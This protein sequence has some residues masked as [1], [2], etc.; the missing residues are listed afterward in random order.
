M[1]RLST[2]LLLLFLALFL[3]PPRSEA[4][5]QASSFADIDRYVSSQLSSARIPGAALGIVHGNQ[6]AHLRGFGRADSSSRRVSPTTPFVIGSVS[7]SFTALAVM[8]LVEAGKITLDRPVQRYIPW[9][10]T[11]NRAASRVMSVRD[12]LVQTSGIPTSVGVTPLAERTTTLR[13]Q[14]EALSGVDTG[15]AGS[16][17]EYSNANYEILGQLV[18]TVSGEPYG[19]YVQEHI[20]RPL[21]MRH[22]YMDEG[23]ARRAGLAAGHQLFFGAVMERTAF[24]RPDFLPAGFIVSSAVDMTHYLVAQMNGGVYQSRSILSRSGISTM[25][26]PVVATGGLGSSS[27]YGMGW[28]TSTVSGIRATWHDGSSFDMHSV[29]LMDER[30]HWGVALLYNGTAPLYELVQNLDAIGWGVL[31]KL[32]GKSPPGT[33]EGLYIGFDAAVALITAL[34]IRTLVSLVRGG[35]GKIS[36]WRVGARVVARFVPDWVKTVFR[37]YYRFVVPVLLLW[38]VPSFLNASWSALVK[39]DIGLWLLVF[40]F[41][42]LFTGCV[43]MVR[44]AAFRAWFRRRLGREATARQAA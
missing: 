3:L 20:L 16:H 1:K 22:T 24:Y 15:A 35:G 28:F 37:A 38:R 44:S 30:H 11:A 43:W 18:E 4:A 31:A 14:V 36:R 8:Q 32:D 13:K 25:H 23:R 10:H 40:V 33:G 5:T 29:V 7:K 27:Q 39:T 34:Q 17:F 26:R 9:F 12:L 42:Q 6:I 21:Q 2:T 19:R 41:L